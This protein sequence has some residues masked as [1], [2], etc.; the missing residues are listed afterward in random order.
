MS[1]LGWGVGLGLHTGLS[2]LTFYVSARLLQNYLQGLERMEKEPEHMT[3]EQGEG[4]GTAAS[5]PGAQGS[6]ARTDP[7]PSLAPCL[8]LFPMPLLM[9]LLLLSSPLPLCPPRL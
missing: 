5:G 1:G 2:G 3:R 7:G 8:H 9:W 4:L 6:R